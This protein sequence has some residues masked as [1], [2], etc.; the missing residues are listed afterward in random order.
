MHV[1]SSLFP[2]QRNIISFLC[3]PSSP[4]S[5]L[6]VIKTTGAVRRFAPSDVSQRAPLHDVLC[7]A[8]ALLHLPLCGCTPLRIVYRFAPDGAL[9]HAYIFYPTYYKVCINNLWLLHTLRLRVSILH[10]H[11]SRHLRLIL[12]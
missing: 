12:R 1:I 10:Y 6:L 7:S 8:L 4:L 2:L 5:S 3:L 9:I 11:T